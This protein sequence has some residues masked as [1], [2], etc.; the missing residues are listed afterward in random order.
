[1]M[2]I[3]KDTPHLG[4][5]IMILAMMEKLTSSVTFAGTPEVNALFL[6]HPNIKT[7]P[8]EQL[9]TWDIDLSDITYP[10]WDDYAKALNVEWDG[11]PPTLEVTSEELLHHK[12]PDTGWMKVGVCTTSRDKHRCYPHHKALVKRLQK[13]YDVYVFGREQL[14][15]RELV[16]KVSQ[17][18]KMVSVD[19]GIAHIAGCLG[20]PLII[21]AG[22]TDCEK[23]YAPYGNVVIASTD[24][25]RCERK[26]CVV[27]ACK[28]AHCM[29]LIDPED[30]KDAITEPQKTISQNI[31]VPSTSQKDNQEKI[32]IVRMKG[33]GDILMTWFGLEV[34]RRENPKAHI[35]Y[36]TSDNGSE[37]FYG[38]GNLVDKVFA[39]DWDYPPEGIPRLPA[40]IRNLP[41]DRLLELDNRIDFHDTIEGSLGDRKLIHTSPRADNFAKLMGVNL[42][43][44]VFHRML[45]IPDEME[46]YASEVTSVF[47]DKMLISCQLDAK[48]ATRLWHID[49]WIQLSKLLVKN[50]YGVIWFSLT[51]EH[52]YLKLDG[53]LNLSCQTSLSQMIALM[54]KCRYAIST[55]SA[56]IHIAHRLSKTI[57]IGIYGS[58]DYKLL[59]T[60]YDDLIPIT[61]YSMDCTPCADW[62]HECLR[63]PGAPWCIN[64]ISPKRIVNAITQAKT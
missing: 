31:D 49:R 55:C 29:Y 35:T 46:K 32:V 36:I 61:N 25:D 54:S 47:G 60:Y 16:S 48:G 18:D 63:Q 2:I 34:L 1:M 17:L 11:K 9:T 19:T 22:P 12:L 26:P 56:S 23:L 44:N 8:V 51:P 41:H 27:D 53:V 5:G 10:R 20:V 30:V 37:L 14:P 7:T 64:Q 52:Q 15:I 45:K 58:T 40:S 28:Q 6:H 62:G 33:I 3:R 38:Q 21:I 57:P 50:G 42:D 13:H 39:V 4:D 24:K 59:A 43:G